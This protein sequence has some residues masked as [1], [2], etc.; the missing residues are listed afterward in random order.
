ML[1]KFDYSYIID[2]RVYL[3]LLVVVDAKMYEFYGDNLEN[4]VLTLMFLVNI[5]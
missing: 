1:P 5:Q 2:R 3:E 4:H